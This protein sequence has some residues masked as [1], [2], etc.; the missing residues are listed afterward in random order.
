MTKTTKQKT[1]SRVSQELLEMADDMHR[2][3]IMDGKTHHQITV[4]HLGRESSAAFEAVWDNPED[5][6]YNAL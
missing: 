2:I 3:G 5:A 4:H 6:A 1:P